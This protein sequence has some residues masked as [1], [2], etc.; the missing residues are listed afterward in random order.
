M[1]RPLAPARCM[2]TW[3]GARRTASGNVSAEKTK[4]AEDAGAQ[5][6][7]IDALI[8]ACEAEPDPECEEAL[9]TQARLDHLARICAPD[10]RVVEV[11]ARSAAES[12]P[13]SGR[14]VD[15]IGDV[16][17]RKARWTT[18]GFEQRV[19]DG[20]AFFS[21]TP[22]LGHLKMATVRGFD[23]PADCFTKALTEGDMRRHCEAV[24]QRW[25]S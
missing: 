15:T 5:R 7:R 25:L 20:E 16:G 6:R 3:A 14:W 24:G 18:R 8:A 11:V 13:L 12:R 21:A 22:S 10:A 1:R 4:V 17:A 23:N 2:R 9:T 19:R